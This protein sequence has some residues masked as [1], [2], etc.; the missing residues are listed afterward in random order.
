MRFMG[1][2]R[3]QVN[4]TTLRA[5]RLRGAWPDIG[6]VVGPATTSA[7]GG[8]GLGGGGGTAEKGEQRI[9]GGSVGQDVGRP[10]RVRQSGRCA[11]TV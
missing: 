9:S 8:W 10:V 1:T 5:A 2:A 11:R 6:T 4:V 3:E 7:L